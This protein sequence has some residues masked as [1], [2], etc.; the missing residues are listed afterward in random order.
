[1]AFKH[2]TDPPTQWGAAEKAGKLVA[3]GLLTVEDFLP[4]LMA[5]AVKQGFKGDASGTQARLAWHMRDVADAWG[6]R[7]N[8]CSRRI[9]KGIAGLLAEWAP[10]EEILAEAHA[11][12]EADDEPLL[13]SEVKRLVAG[14]MA[15]FMRFNARKRR[16]VG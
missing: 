10:H 6:I 14:E 8:E 13:R 3:Q 9:R 7:R 5:A 16:R 15:E 4:T 2:P 12:N 11:I 1:M